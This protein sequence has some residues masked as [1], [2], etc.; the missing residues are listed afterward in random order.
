MVTDPSILAL[1][2][3]GAVAAAVAV[4]E[5]LHVRRVRRVAR[6]AFGASGHPAPWV[7]AVPFLRVAAAGAAAWGLVFL[8]SF[9]PV[10]VETKPDPR[11][12]LHLLVCL[13]VSPSMQ[14]KDAGPEVEKLSRAAWAGRVVQG[15]LDRLDMTVTRISIVGF[16]T[17]ALP[18]VHE[19]FDKEVVRN[20][21]DGLPM[22]VAFEPGPTDLQKGLTK[23]IEI[24][25]PWPAHS[26]T[27]LV[28]SDGDASAAMPPA[29]P[30]SIADTIVI[31]VGDP[32]RSSVVG[33]H[34]SRQDASSLK[35]LALRLGGVYHDGNV[36]HLPSAV[37]D[38]LT[39]I[40]PRRA[41]RL[42]T[43][44]LALLAT[45][46]GCSTLA[47][48]GPAMMLFGRPRAFSAA[49][50]AM[51]RRLEASAHAVIKESAT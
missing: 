15:V 50:R 10:D 30:A 1:L 24:A 44:D 34:S 38:R 48:L 25:K 31:G 49:R 5:A 51:D 40:S 18:V 12:S 47:L 26:A 6:L 35:Q 17:D 45:G 9:D 22:Y 21:L 33:G 3:A 23:A 37:L 27:L 13:D 43:R 41:D 29:L 14:V 2:V 19:T 20:A 4:A 8:A 32:V 36:K 39:M 7:R 11:A 46:L 42:S 28:V 16:Y